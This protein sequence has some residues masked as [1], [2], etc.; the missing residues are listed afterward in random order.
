MKRDHVGDAM[1]PMRIHWG[2][3]LEERRLRVR[4]RG[5]ERTER[6]H[7]MADSSGGIG[8]GTKGKAHLA[9][10]IKCVINE[11]YAVPCRKEG[12]EVFVPFSFLRKYFEV[13]GK[14]A[15]RDGKEVL[16]WQ[17]SYSKVMAPNAMYHTAGPF[18]WFENYNVAVRDRVKCISGM[19]GKPV[20]SVILIA[21]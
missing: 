14:I 10:E 9:H 15:Y 18:L 2:A 21:E 5:G 19:E 11:D 6:P 20:L 3:L 1:P 8:V 7:P 16:D 17:H 12:S 13:Y 4:R